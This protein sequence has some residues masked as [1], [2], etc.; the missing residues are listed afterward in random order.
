MHLCYK[1]QA[2]SLSSSTETLL[3]QTLPLLLCFLFVCDTVSINRV[4]LYHVG[5]NSLNEVGP[6]Y[7]DL[8]HTGVACLILPNA[9]FTGHV[10]PCMTQTQK[11][12]Q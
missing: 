3:I 10:P 7:T 11:T 12:Q 4:T 5:E 2:S 6:E 8:K 9:G 1:I